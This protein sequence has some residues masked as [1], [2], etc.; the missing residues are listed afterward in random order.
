[1]Q[2]DRTNQVTNNYRIL[3]KD[4]QRQQENKK[5]QRDKHLARRDPKRIIDEYV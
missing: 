2:V 1:M 3:R 5:E 4:K